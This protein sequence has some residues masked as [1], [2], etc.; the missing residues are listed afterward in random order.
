MHY[1]AYQ[2]GNQ[3]GTREFPAAYYYIDESSPNYNMPFHWH[4]EWELI[5]ILQGDFP[6]S[7]NGVCYT[8]GKGD[9]FLLRGDML[10]GGAPHECIY[11]CF[12]FD[13]HGLFR[14]VPSVKECLRPFYQNRL[15]P[16]I[17]YPDRYP[18]IYG[19]AEELFAAF[20][21]DTSREY[22]ALATIGNISRLFA[23]ILQ[24]GCY[25]E[26]NG[27]TSSTARKITQLKPVLEYIEANFA[28][29]LSLE[30]LA[31][32]AGMNPKYFCRLFYSIIQE[33]PMNYVNVYRIEQAANLL[34]ATDLSVTEAGLECGFND[35]CHFVKTFKK[36]K[37]TTP[38]QYQKLNS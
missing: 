20:S 14:D 19:I 27:G 12:D 22:Q 15:L 10:H 29:P 24:Q 1:L 17:Y 28:E 16:A 6:L 36:Y 35:T 5:R 31:K 11:Q 9:I 34:C 4:K 2:D 38:K 21:Q 26:N 13:L 18:A 25:A 7:V 37:G 23:A 8:A 33:T 3:H 30:G 32:V